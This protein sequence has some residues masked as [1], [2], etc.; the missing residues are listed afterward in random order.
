MEGKRFEAGTFAISRAGHDAGQI[1][2]IL[3]ERKEEVLIADGRTRTVE[4]P[5]RKK[6]KHLMPIKKTDSEL[7]EKCR[8]KSIRN[9]EIKKAIQYCQRNISYSISD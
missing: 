2:L 5:K 9:E 6:K 7:I 4:K 8:E 3:E 1:F